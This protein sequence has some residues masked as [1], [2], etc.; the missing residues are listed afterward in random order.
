MCSRMFENACVYLEWNVLFWSLWCVHSLGILSTS[1]L[2]KHL[3]ASGTAMEFLF[4]ILKNALRHL[5]LQNLV[6]NS[7][8]SG[9][10]TLDQEISL[11]ECTVRRQQPRPKSMNCW[12]K[13]ASVLCW[14][15]KYWGGGHSSNKY[16]SIP[17]LVGKAIKRSFFLPSAIDLAT[18]YHLS[19][20]RWLLSS[21]DGCLWVCDCVVRS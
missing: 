3:P 10:S 17:C 6:A 2:I 13:S 8:F 14:I 4:A 12:F 7:Y 21:V 1:V 18:Y 15:L 11:V 19:L 9:S 16:P 20:S 5:N